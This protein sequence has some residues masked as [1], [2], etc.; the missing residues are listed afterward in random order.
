MSRPHTLF[1]ESF[2]LLL[3]PNHYMFRLSFIQHTRSPLALNSGYIQSIYR[4]TTNYELHDNTINN[5]SGKPL[6]NNTPVL[7]DLHE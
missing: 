7:F 6:K 4:I 3:G 5:H 1:L 2:I